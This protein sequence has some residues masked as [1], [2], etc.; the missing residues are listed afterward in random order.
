MDK[1]S[2]KE[3]DYALFGLT[4]GDG[5]YR[6]GYIT[7]HHTNKQR[8][9]ISWLES[10]CRTNDIRCSVRYDDVMSTTFGKKMY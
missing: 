2:K 1:L 10:F 6:N 3:I 7:A 4:L 5:S 9:Y 8:F